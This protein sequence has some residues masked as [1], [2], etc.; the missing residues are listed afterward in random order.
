MSTKPED[1]GLIEETSFD[2]SPESGY[3]KWLER[4]MADGLA[5]IE[6]GRTTP[7]NEVWSELG[8]E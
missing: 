1:A 3:D 7:A 6:A 8:I 2:G 4:E 5:D